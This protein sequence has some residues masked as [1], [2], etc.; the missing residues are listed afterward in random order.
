MLFVML[1]ISIVMNQKAQ[2][3][4]E[5]QTP[6]RNEGDKITVR[7]GAYENEPK[8]FTDSE[9]ELVGLFP[10]ILNHIAS[11]E[12]WDIEYVN[13]NWTQCLDR[14]ESNEIDFMVDVGYSEE[15]ADRFAFSNESVLVNWG[16]VYTTPNSDIYSISDLQDSRVAVMNDSIH[17]A[18]EDGIINLVERFD[19]NCT[20]IHVENYT[21]VFE[22]L[23]SGEVDA[24]VVNRIFGIINEPRYEIRQTSIL[25]NPIELRFAFT[26]DAP[27]TQYLID[28]IDVNLIE[29]KQDPD[30]VYYRSMDKYLSNPGD[31]DQ[32]SEIPFW[33]ISTFLG[34]VFL[35]VLF[36]AMNMVLKWKVDMKTSELL[37]VNKNLEQEIVERKEAEKSERNTRERLRE[38]IEFLPDPILVI[39]LE[40]RVIAWNNAMVEMTGIPKED[41]IGKGDHEYAIPFYGERQPVLIDMILRPDEETERKYKYQRKSKDLLL[42]ETEDAMLKG[43]RRCLL[44]KAAPIYD[45]RGNLVGAIESSRDITE[46]K[47]AQRELQKLNEELEQ[48]V[49]DRTEELKRANDKL[50][51]LDRLKSM[52]IASMSHELRT[53]LNSIIGFTGILLMG[54]VGDLTQEQIKQLTMVKNSANHLLQ[55]INDVIDISKIEAGM[56]S[57]DIEEFDLC[58]I[59]NDVMESFRV[60]MNEKGLSCSIEIPASF[61][62]CSDKRRVR[63]VMVNLVGNAVKFTDEGEVS[64]RFISELDEGSQH[65]DKNSTEDELA[66]RTHS[67]RERP[68]EDKRIMI[69]IRDTG[70]GIH[71]KDLD[72][73]FRPFS[74]ITTEGRVVQ[75]SGL[76]LHIT[77]KILELL[78]GSISVKSEYGKGTE[79]TFSLPVGKTEVNP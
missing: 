9:G 55:L 26:K 4:E 40:G 78:D 30:S 16:T 38:I 76:G 3:C 31:D 74:Q 23:E 45:T 68:R 12:D 79:F 44:D 19:V 42:A 14:L 10:D 32:A 61:M 71:E 70:P 21:E 58:S 64:V 52:F 17:T 25:F 7:V 47:Q 73:L 29:M 35:M 66:D 67:E 36:I 1:S 5:D 75:G 63:Q 48:R 6:V 11:K 51:E 20:F 72:R 59:I 43:E 37:V 28:R 24:G 33:L 49:M 62:V 18:G 41:M 50:K 65:D 60:Q 56:V 27:L 54:M 34:L 8:I 15:R 39:D 77:R 57:L 53:P 69:A 2:A 22:L 13:G 46:Q